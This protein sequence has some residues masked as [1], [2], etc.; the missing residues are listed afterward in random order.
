M[1]M[2]HRLL[3]PIVRL[4]KCWLIT[5]ERSN[6]KTAITVNYVKMTIEL[7]HNVRMWMEKQTKA[8]ADRWPSNHNN[9]N[10]DCHLFDRLIRTHK[11]TSISTSMKC[12]LIKTNR[13]LLALLWLFLFL[14]AGFFSV[15]ASTQLLVNLA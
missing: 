11:T 13:I 7:L 4:Y 6:E 12:N 9:F 3:L 10:D 8:A 1:K 5:E 15:A 2:W 14:I